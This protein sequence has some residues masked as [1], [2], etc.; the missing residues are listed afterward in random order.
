MREPS[1]KGRRRQTALKQKPGGKALERLR[2]FELER[3]LEPT[4]ITTPEP[5]RS[6]RERAGKTQDKDRGGP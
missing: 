3:G 4:A 2:Q 6:P 5:R 1:S